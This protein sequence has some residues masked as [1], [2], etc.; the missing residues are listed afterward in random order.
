[1]N[2]RELEKARRNNLN[3]LDTAFRPKINAVEIDINNSVE[4]ELAKFIC[5]WLIRKGV[6]TDRLQTFFDK[7]EW[8]LDTEIPIKEHLKWL[9]KLIEEFV[10]NEASI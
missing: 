6:N 4:H 1:M 9:S 8:G 3:K 10:K 2:Q 7:N 5:V